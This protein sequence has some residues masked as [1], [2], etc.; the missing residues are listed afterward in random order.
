M[1]KKKKE[2]NNIFKNLKLTWRMTKGARRYMIGFTSCSILLSLVGGILP[3]LRGK[4]MLHLS[5]SVWERLITVA[6]AILL[7]ELSINVIRTLAGKFGNLFYRAT[8]KNIQIGLA[9]ETLKLETEEIDN[10]TSGLF[11]DRLS[12]DSSRVA[13]IFW[14]LFDVMADVIINFGIL[15]AVFFVSKIMFVFFLATSIVLFSINRLRI[16]KRFEIDK[17]KRKFNEKRTG[18]IS[19]MIRGLRD[20]KVLNCE[21]SFTNLVGDYITESNRLSYKMN[22]VNRRWSLLAGS[23]HDLIDAAFVFLGI[24]LVTHK[25]LV[26]ESL[27]ILFM[28]SQ[29]I[30]N[31][32]NYFARMFEIFK[33]FNLSAGRVFELFEDG[34]FKKEKFGNIHLDKV[35]GGFEFKKVNFLYRKNIP[36]LKNLSFKINPNETVAFVGRSGG[37]KTTIFSLLTKLYHPQSGTILIDGYNINDLDK[38]TLRGNISII[39]QNPYIFNLSIKDNLKIVKPKLTKKEMIDVCKRAC[40]YD[41]IE[42]LPKKYNTV[43]GEGGITLSGGQRQRLAIARAFLRNTEIILFDE[44]TSALDNETQSHIQEAIKNLQKDK[45]ILIIAHRLSTVINSDRI[46]VVDGGKIVG[47][48]THTELLKN[49]KIYK[50][51]YETELQKEDI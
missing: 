12:G 27:V 28:Y 17:E 42:K 41:D 5:N 29:R 13:D 14:E 43:I 39:T 38:D 30:Y 46:L 31:L 2:Q 3:A 19:E 7:F 10:N 16:K 24:Y 20:V 25:L 45:T 48:G 47:E 23:I 9:K 34:K 15:V 51:L 21:E 1:K 22:E 33:E 50:E 40:L 36:V 26:V 18:L 44:A 37:G 4:Q 8:L 49:N 35:E 6:I 32:L 11:I